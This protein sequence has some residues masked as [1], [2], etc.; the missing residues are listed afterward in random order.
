MQRETEKFGCRANTLHPPFSVFN[1]ECR[2]FVVLHVHDFLCVGGGVGLGSIAQSYVAQ[3][4]I[5]DLKNTL[6]RW[7]GGQERSTSIG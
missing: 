3:K 7:E 5:H 1:R 2:V 6:A 4:A